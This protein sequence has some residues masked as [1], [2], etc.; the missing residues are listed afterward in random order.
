MKLRQGTRIASKD[1]KKEYI[2]TKRD[3]VMQELL[4]IA[5]VLGYEISYTEDKENKREYLTVN[6][7]NICTN[8]TSIYGIRQEF[9]GYVFLC[10]WRKRSIGYFDTQTR[11]AIKSY[12]YDENFKQPYCKGF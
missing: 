10:E 3:E 1:G 11:N 5:K 2:V 6:G 8:C 7:T 4:P 9:I 12:W